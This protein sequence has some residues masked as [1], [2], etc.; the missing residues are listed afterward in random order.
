MLALA[1]LPALLFP[2][3]RPRLRARS[4]VPPGEPGLS[5]HWPPILPR[6]A[7]TSVLLAGV[8][9]V[10]LVRVA[11]HYAVAGVGPTWPLLAAGVGFSV[12]WLVAWLVLTASS[13]GSV[14]RWRRS[15]PLS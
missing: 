7:L 14:L 2:P 11:D 6:L 13:L 8:S 15:A 4:A 12:F 5:I 9:V 3:S 10:V 1:P